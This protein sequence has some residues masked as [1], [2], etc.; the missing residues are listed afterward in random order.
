[1]GT[2]QTASELSLLYSDVTL[3]FRKRKLFNNYSQL[4]PVADTG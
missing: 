2:L 4:M 1:V 3:T